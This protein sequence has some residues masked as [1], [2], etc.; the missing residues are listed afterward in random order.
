ML[1]AALEGVGAVALIFLLSHR[2]TRSQ[3][4]DGSPRPMPGRA[5]TTR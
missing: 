1:P 2:C 5:Q 4:V 3:R